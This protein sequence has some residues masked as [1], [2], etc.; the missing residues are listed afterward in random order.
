MIKYKFFILLI[1]GVI[2]MGCRDED[3]LNE[4]N[5]DDTE[6]SVT[7][8]ADNPDYSDW[9]VETHSNSAALN[10][11]VVFAQDTVKRFDI[12]ISSS[13]W[14]TMQSDLAANLGSTS[15]PGGGGPGGG[16]NN[17]ATS[18]YDPVWVPCSFKYNNTE[19]YH[20]GVRF[21]GNSSLQSA[22]QSGNGKL[23]FKLDFDEF[24]DDYPTIKN[25]RFYGFK[26]LHINN[27][28]NDA[29]LMRDK[30][31]ADLFRKFGLIAAQTSFCELYVDNGSGPEYYGLYTIIEEVSNTVIA[32]Q[33]GDDSGNLY[34]PDGT[35]ASFANGTYNDDEMVKK[36]NEDLNDYSDVKALYD[37]INSSDRTSNTETWK[38]N[39][40]N[41]LDVDVFLKW[42]AANT[43][44][45]NWDT[46]GR[47]THNFY[48]YNNHNTNLLNWI[49]WDNNEA[50]QYG[51]NGGALSFSMSEVGSSWPLISYL[52]AIPEYNT[53]YENYLN[54]FIN[55]VFIPSELSSIYDSYYNLLKE[56]AY[57]ERSGYTYIGS[58][59]NFDAAVDELKAHVTERNNAVINYLQ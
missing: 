3:A 50:L 28:Y 6:E 12:I 53:I 48:L 5:D 41:V 2:L 59:S 27:N 46:Y 55:T 29:S 33:T 15:G 1:I 35:A 49:P 25:Q 37:V 39:L 16:G 19:W 52:I 22:Y 9:T 58:D 14:S 18:D 26:K 43:V 57:N 30:V 44:I 45:Q 54:E 20:V 24:E 47:M 17:L 34:K 36:N 31:A 7:N 13:N 51:K 38:T 23:S 42:L 11:D 10:Y 4:N 40:E 32:T 56:F 21:K 8:P